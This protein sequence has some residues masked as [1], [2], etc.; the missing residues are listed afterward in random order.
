VSAT[1]TEKALSQIRSQNERIRALVLAGEDRLAIAQPRVSAWS[2]A[3]H[4]DHILK[5]AASVVRRINQPDA[6]A[7]PNGINLLGRAVLLGGWIPRGRGKSPER[8]A[9]TRVSGAEI[10][11]AIGKL[12]TMLRAVVVETCQSSRTPTVPHPRFG[13]LTPSQALRFA[14]VHTNHHLRIVEDIL[15]EPGS[16]LHS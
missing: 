16:G 10:E 5:V 6:E 9:G 8:L 7:G 1:T 15:G 11:T 13:G 3:E 14:V 12:E 2:V 4:L